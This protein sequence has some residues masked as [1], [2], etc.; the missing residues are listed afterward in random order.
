MIIISTALKNLKREIT[1]NVFTILQLAFTFIIS[2]V[3]VSSIMLRYQY[4]VPFKDY[5]QSNGIMTIFGI[6]ANSDTDSNGTNM[7]H[8][9][10]NNEILQ[11]LD[12]S[13]DILA[14]NIV[15]AN[16]NDN[17]KYDSTS[18]SYND[19]IINKFTPEL[20]D[21]RWLK[22]SSNATE[23]EVVVSEN[24]QNINVGD[25]INFE[26]YNYPDESF[27][28]A[29]VV[30]K[31]K[32]GAKIPGNNKIIENFTDFY[33][34]YN[35]SVEQKVL[36][37]FSSEYLA[38]NNKEI[39]QFLQPSSIIKYSENVS[40][41]QLEKQKNLLSN[42]GA[43][44]SSSLKKIDKNSKR[45]LYHDVYNL[46]PII[47]MLLILVIVS[48]ISSTA[49]STRR[50][51]KDY[52]IY[53]INGLQWKH[54]VIINLFQSVFISL[55]SIIISIACA[56]FIQIS[57]FADNIK[58]IWNQYTITTIIAILILYLSVSMIMPAIIIGKNT[59]KQILTR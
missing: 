4:Y 48:S 20:Q 58:I 1:I 51:L 39:I 50:R 47:T 9:L 7:F 56:K 37:I 57:I 13:E 27:H 42:Y 59:P 11:Y 45:Y 19:N 30:G 8:Y 26:F 22:N 34:P 44:F 2:I 17:K 36:F 41:E 40:E 18:Y 16:D 10:K 21:G 33:I 43:V 5:F 32:E 25:T 31:L 52:S 29:K 46:L 55:I 6:G 35:F 12:G 3:M 49:L 24:D 14:C 54:C 53:Y 15:W 38:K 28:S 23:M